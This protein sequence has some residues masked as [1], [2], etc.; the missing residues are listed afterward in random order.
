MCRCSYMQEILIILFSVKYAPFELELWLD[1]QCIILNSFKFIVI[2]YTVY[3]YIFKGNSY[4]IWT[5]ILLG[6]KYIILWK[7]I[8]IGLARVHEFKWQISCL[9]MF[10]TVNVQML[11]KC[12]NHLSIM[13]V[14]PIITDHIRFDCASLMHDIGTISLQYFQASLERGVCELAHSF[15]Y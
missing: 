1:I 3:M 12:D 7:L 5:S 11:H 6:K 15:F 13:H 10:L 4:L 14:Y 2:V 8:E 9:D